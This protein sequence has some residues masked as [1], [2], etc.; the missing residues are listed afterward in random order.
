MSGQFG[1]KPNNVVHAGRDEELTVGERGA[2]DFG[3]SHLGVCYLLQKWACGGE[4]VIGILRWPH[5]A[6]GV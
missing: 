2:Y 1:F 6:N 5:C 4:Q 3:G